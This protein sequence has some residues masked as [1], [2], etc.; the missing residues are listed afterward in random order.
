MSQRNK[1]KLDKLEPHYHKRLLSF[2]IQLKSPIFIE[3]DNKLIS[4]K[5]SVETLLNFI[6]NC[7]M[8][9]ITN[10]E[11]NNINITK[12]KIILEFLKK[13]LHSNLHIKNKIYNSLKKENEAKKK[14]LQEQM[15]I[16][17]EF[18]RE[19]GNTIKNIHSE[20]NQLKILNFQIENEIKSTDFLIKQKSR[21][22]CH[23]ENK[24]IF[25]N[26]NSGEVIKVSNIMNN[27]LN[28]NQN[29]LIDINKEILE[30]KN[31]IH[32]IN[33]QISGLKNKIIEIKGE[34]K[35]NRYNNA[36][37]SNK[38]KIKRNNS[39]KI[40]I[41]KYWK[42]KLIEKNILKG[43]VFHRNHFSNCNTIKMNQKELNII[44]NVY[45]VNKGNKLCLN[46]NNIV[47]NKIVNNYSTKNINI[48]ENLIKKVIEYSLHS[49]NSSID[50]N[51]L[52]CECNNKMIIKDIEI[53]EKLNKK[54]IS[55]S[56]DDGT[57]YDNSNESSNLSVTRY[58]SSSKKNDSNKKQKLN[59]EVE[60]YIF[61]IM[62]DKD[63]N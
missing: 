4:H 60:Q 62:S 33:S 5:S 41:N 7:Q 42:N 32:S 29:I 61:S 37:I 15:M 43:E 25:C 40:I 28:D 22:I 49:F 31:E 57:N 56:S 63:L 59:N 55:P 45:K 47:N 20:K 1:N 3:P 2:D 26:H 24:E 50:S 6:K 13:Q 58:K 12:T 51:S 39:E 10:K 17:N 44:K 46:S 21:K 52:S 9:Y 19:S 36:N 11:L 16:D 35:L 38:K 53:M 54:N 14:E 30:T 48:N 34:I 18:E 8:E 27:N 23:K